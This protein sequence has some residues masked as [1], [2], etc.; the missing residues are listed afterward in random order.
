MINMINHDGVRLQATA[1]KQ[2]RYGY[3]EME[4]ISVEE[5]LA[6]L[7]HCK[8]SEN[9]VKLC[10]TIQ[11]N[12]GRSTHVRTQRTGNPAARSQIRRQERPA[13][14]RRAAGTD[15]AGSADGLLA[16]DASDGLAFSY[17]QDWH[18]FL[19]LNQELKC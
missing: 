1:L 11:E 8:N 17:I 16:A 9:I 2:K 12:R 6:D 13:S 5:F 18:I 19:F 14:G 3:S 10:S 15:P 4:S 7:S